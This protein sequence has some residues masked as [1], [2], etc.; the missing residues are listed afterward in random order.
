MKDGLYVTGRER[1][2]CPSNTWRTISPA[3]ECSVISRAGSSF[4]ACLIVISEPVTYLL[5]SCERLEQVRS[6]VPPI[7]ILVLV[8]SSSATVTDNNTVVAV[9]IEV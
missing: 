2:S 3:W 5:R 6:M 7:M 9:A 4:C 1:K 8:L